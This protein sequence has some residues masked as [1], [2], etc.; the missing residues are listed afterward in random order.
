MHDSASKSRVCVNASAVGYYG[1]TSEATFDESAPRGEG[2]L[3]DLVEKWEA[4]AH[5]AH[6]LARVVLLRFGIVLGRSGGALAQMLPPFRFGA[7]G[8]IG[9]GEQWMSWVDREDVVRA[10]EWAI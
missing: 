1:Y 8:P 2:F 9:S 6:S 4:A 7:G 3:A 5:E 10:I